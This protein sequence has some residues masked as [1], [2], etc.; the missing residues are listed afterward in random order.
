[1]STG[2]LSAVIIQLTCVKPL[3]PHRT[4]NTTNPDSSHTGQSLSIDFSSTGVFLLVVLLEIK[5]TKVILFGAFYSYLLPAWALHRQITPPII[6]RLHYRLI[7]LKFSAG[8]LRGS[9]LMSASRPTVDILFELSTALSKHDIVLA[10]CVLR[11][12][13]KDKYLLLI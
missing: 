7:H 4:S 1:M 13:S 11:S 9:L 3:S 10:S 12:L 2:T 5:V 6:D 8:T